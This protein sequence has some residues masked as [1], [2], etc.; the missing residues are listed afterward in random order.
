M[1]ETLKIMNLMVMVYINV[2]NSIIME[3]LLMEKKMEKEK[4][5][6]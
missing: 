1:K 4:S 6:I 2:K 3:I 5:K